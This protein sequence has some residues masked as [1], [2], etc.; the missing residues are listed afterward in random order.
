LRAALDHKVGVAQLPDV[1]LQVDS[2]V[3]FSWIMLGREARSDR[4]LLMVYDGILAHGTSMSA[5]ETARMI[6]QV[7]AATIRQAMRWAGAERRLAQASAAVLAYMRQ[8][9]IAAYAW[10]LSV[11]HRPLRRRSDAVPGD[12]QNRETGGINLRRRCRKTHGGG[13]TRKINEIRELQ[14][15]YRK[16]PGNSRCFYR[17]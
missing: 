7:S 12:A 16:S 3:R 10:R 17:H 6:P 2:K 5:A 15:T 8:H 11:S 9:P 14:A 1:L 13:G 4:E